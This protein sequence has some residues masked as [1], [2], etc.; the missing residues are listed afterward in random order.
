MVP[1]IEVATATFQRPETSLA[2]MYW[3]YSPGEELSVV[4]LKQVH[5]VRLKP[6]VGAPEQSVESGRV[7]A[8]STLMV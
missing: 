7:A 8:V 4:F 6:R 3:M 2:Q 1:S 5:P